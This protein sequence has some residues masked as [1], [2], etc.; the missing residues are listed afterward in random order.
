M[1]HIDESKKQSG[2]MERRS[3]GCELQRIF[4][5]LLPRLDQRFL[6]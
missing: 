3:S 4:Y 5:S 1:T 6:S 2:T